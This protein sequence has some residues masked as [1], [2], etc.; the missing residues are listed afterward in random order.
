MKKCAF[1]GK[2]EWIDKK[3]REMEINLDNIKSS[4]GKINDSEKT[5]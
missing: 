2:S 4:P 5:T 3:E 1:L